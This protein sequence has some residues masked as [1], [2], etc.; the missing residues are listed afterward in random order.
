MLLVLLLGVL[1][2]P[3]DQ[4]WS[5]TQKNCKY[6]NSLRIHPRSTRSY[7]STVECLTYRSYFITD[8]S[9]NVSSDL[10]TIAVPWSFL[11]NLRLERSKKYLL[12]GVFSLGIFVIISACLTKYYSLTPTYNPHWEL[13]YISE[14]ST[15]ILVGNIPLCLPLM[16]KVMDKIFVV[17]HMKRSIQGST[18]DDLEKNEI[19]TS[20]QNLAQRG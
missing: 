15:A 17:R 20:T 6:S 9:L 1:C 14:A 11:A 19:A 7:I 13:W 8:L 5:L 16:R 3:L 18:A 2:R 12:V 10:F 4:Y